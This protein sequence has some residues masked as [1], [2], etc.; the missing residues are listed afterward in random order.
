MNKQKIT[1]IA[2]SVALFSIVQYVIYEKIVESR[3]EELSN[4]YQNGYNRGLTDAAVTIY[5]QTENCQ[6]ATI[7]IGNSTKTVFDLSCLK[8]QLNNTLH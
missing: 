2:L 1:I 4:A 3:Q 7:T 6:S 8:T 5:K